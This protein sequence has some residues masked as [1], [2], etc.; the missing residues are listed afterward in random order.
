MVYD[1][2]KLKISLKTCYSIG[3]F[4]KTVQ[5]R[6]KKNQESRSV[7]VD[8]GMNINASNINATQPTINILCFE[9]RRSLAIPTMMKIMTNTH[10]FF[11][12]GKNKNFVFFSC[13]NKKKTEIILA[14]NLSQL[15]S[16]LTSF[17]FHSYV[18]ECRGM[19]FYII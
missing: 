17:C 16:S 10:F 18:F 9:R 3:F 4:V 19:C 2:R 6:Y 5:L 8:A 11:I 1:N 14:I 13:R 15:S 7:E 12:K